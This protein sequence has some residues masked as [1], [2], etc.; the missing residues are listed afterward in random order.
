LTSQELAPA[1]STEGAVWLDAEVLT[2]LLAEAET[3]GEPIEL[4]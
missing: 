1:T 3:V 4:R 2:T